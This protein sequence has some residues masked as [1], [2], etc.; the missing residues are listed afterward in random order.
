MTT[1]VPEKIIDDA[2]SSRGT[3]NSP[4]VR[5]IEKPDEFRRAYPASGSLIRTWSRE[6]V[7]DMLRIKLQ[8]ASRQQTP[9]GS[10]DMGITEP[11][12]INPETEPRDLIHYVRHAAEGLPVSIKRKLSKNPPLIIRQVYHGRNNQPASDSLTMSP[13]SSDRAKTKPSIVYP[14]IEAQAT[15]RLQQTSPSSPFADLIKPTFS[16]ALVPRLTKPHHSQARHSF[17]PR[18]VRKKSTAID[19]MT[20]HRSFP[21]RRMLSARRREKNAAKVRAHVLR[22]KVNSPVT[23][24]STGYQLLRQNDSKYRA[25]HPSV[26]R[27]QRGE[28]KRN[29]TGQLL[30]VSLLS[31]VVESRGEGIKEVRHVKLYGK[32]EEA[33]SPMDRLHG[34]FDQD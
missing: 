18:V 31:E 7:T 6:P 30:R 27:R 26:A 3:S 17:R 33:Q 24:P 4:S 34:I 19:P 9:H 28:L 12:A 10:L 23:S 11:L 5:K 21:I 22:P 32:Q 2:A 25:L 16:K 14:K 20:P 15:K 13:G 8:V 1:S 29:E